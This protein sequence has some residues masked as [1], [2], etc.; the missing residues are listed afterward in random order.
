MPKP[1]AIWVCDSPNCC[2]IR[3]N[4]GPTNSF[5]P[6]S[7]AMLVCS[8]CDKLDN[9][10]FNTCRDVTTHHHSYT[11]HLYEIE[12]LAFSSRHVSQRTV[13][14]VRCGFVIPKGSWI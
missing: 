10:T 13:T 2:R 7:P 11:S 8:H 6:D 4:R 3:R 5:F 1:S 12:S 9:L 14:N